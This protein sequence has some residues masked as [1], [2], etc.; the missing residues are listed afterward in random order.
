M[1]EAQVHPD[2]ATSV[3]QWG[4]GQLPLPSNHCGEFILHGVY[5]ML[6]ILCHIQ[7]QFVLFCYARPEN[8]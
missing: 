6:F 1:F 5:H 2:R 8:D 3:Y 7:R 4:L